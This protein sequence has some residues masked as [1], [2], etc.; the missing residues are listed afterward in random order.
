MGVSGR[1]IVGVPEGRGLVVLRGG[2]WRG[3]WGGRLVWRERRPT[4]LRPSWPP[5]A[6]GPTVSKPL[7]LHGGALVVGFHTPCL[8][9]GGE[10]PGE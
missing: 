6:G 4:G 5:V 7:P 3:D 2:T 1:G 9:H 8:H 10:I